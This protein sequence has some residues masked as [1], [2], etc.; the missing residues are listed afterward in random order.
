ME[1]EFLSGWDLDT[2]AL[3]AQSYGCFG[4]V[5]ALDKLVKFTNGIPLYVQSI[6]ALSQRETE[7]NL[8]IFCGELDALKHTTETAQEII[9]NKLYE[10]LPVD[11]RHILSVWS[12]SDATLYRPEIISL[13]EKTLNLQEP[14]IIE[15]LR[16]LRAVGIIEIFGNKQLKVHDAIRVIGRR[17]LATMG[18]D[19]VLQSQR[20][21]KEILLASLIE[22]YDTLRLSLFIRTL[23]TLKEVDLLV[24]LSRDEHFHEMGISEE[25]KAFLEPTADSLKSHPRQRFWALDSLVFNETHH[26]RIH[27]T[28]DL[29]NEMEQ[30]VE[31][32]KLGTTENMSYITKR[33]TYEATQ[34]N[35]DKVISLLDAGLSEIPD[36]PMFMRVFKYTVAVSTLELEL[37]E[38]S[39]PILDELISEYFDLIGIQ[40]KDMPG[41][42]S[43]ALLERINRYPEL[44]EDLKK[45]ATILSLR[46]NYLP[47][48]VKTNTRIQ[49]LK[50]YEMAGAY[51]SFIRTAQELADDFIEQQ[52]YIGAKMVM[53]QH[54]M[55]N[56]SNLGLIHRLFDARSQ[57]AV[58]LA[59]CGEFEESRKEMARLDLL[60]SG[61]PIEMQ[62]QIKKQR[63]LIDAIRSKASILRS[64]TKIN[65]KI[66]RNE[67]C[68]CGSEK[69]YKKC[70]GL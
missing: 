51:D 20:S 22:T 34:G 63:R 53:D 45:L 55:P 8:D 5:S 4:S 14:I 1:R 35:A 52:N 16:K 47:K 10:S 19:V 31:E 26:G 46:A 39:L 7:G 62:E 44:H 59:Y 27:E 25:I 49:C 21:L 29:L 18:S 33:M 13:I 50:L 17:N 58:I 15:A 42:N 24:E 12:I 32:Y 9:L 28:G 54:V 3:V 67:P 38:I 36:D 68:P 60:I 70:H 65:K 69:K 40:L 37:Q 56:I 48:I 6:L 43:P 57:Y 23:I 11:A 2:V 61:Q 66:G 30:L 41:N 64:N